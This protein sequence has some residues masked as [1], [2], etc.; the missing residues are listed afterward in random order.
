MSETSD[1]QAR[2]IRRFGNASLVVFAIACACVVQS[3]QWAQTSYYLL[4]QSLASGTATIDNH[5]W[6]TGDKS[7]Y[8]GHYYSVKAPG[9]SLVLVPPFALLRSVGLNPGNSTSAER[10]SKAGLKRSKRMMAPRPAWAREEV[11]RE[12]WMI[13]ALGLIGTV[14]PA[15]GLLWLLRK[16]AELLVPGTGTVSAM[17]VGLG[18]MILPFATQLFG[19][20]MGA[21]FLFLSFHLLMRERRG[22]PSWKLLLFAGLAAG[23]AIVVEYPMAFGGMALGVYAMLRDPK[24]LATAVRRAMAYGGGAL[25][26]LIPLGIYNLAVFG[27][28]T[29]LSYSGAVAVEGKSGH[30][31][32]GLND[33]GFFGIGIPRP[34]AFVDVLF[35]PRGLLTAAPVCLLG[36]IG[37]LWMRRERQHKA[38]AWTALAVVGVYIFYV[39]GYW[40]PFG[41]G[42]PGPRFLVVTLPF[43][44][45]GMPFV[46]RRIPS[47]TAFLA[48][49]SATVMAVATI[50]EPLVTRHTISLWGNRLLG[51]PGFKSLFNLV[52]FPLGA[53]SAIPVLLLL[54]GSAVLAGFATRV[55]GFGTRSDLKVAFAALVSWLLVALLISP[56]IGEQEIDPGL[57]AVGLPGDAVGLPANLVLIA[58]LVG[59]AA[60]VVP[61]LLT[62]QDRSSL[63]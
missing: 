61:L 2:R 32:L 39:S 37:L 59:V 20:L 35:S 38:E 30:A 22:D 33:S 25:V 44:G 18:T 47:A 8:Q 14:T 10:H 60:V 36:F 17:T 3:P 1:S 12:R 21:F 49:V 27:S 15:F 4:T 24:E 48:A 11:R 57:P 16:E 62:R 7:W 52:G 63:S 28:L 56:A 53:G 43:L 51:A 34:M 29:H 46:W 19:H 23:V 40:L 55:S 5:H 9:M 31:K 54:I 42:S 6:Q 50:A 13:W 26:G 41:G 58:S 45:L